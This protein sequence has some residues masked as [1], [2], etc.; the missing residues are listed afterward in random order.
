MKYYTKIA[1]ESPIPVMMYNAP[2]F[3]AGIVFSPDLISALAPHPNIAGMKDTSSENIAIYVNAVPENA[4][5]YVMP[6]TINKMYKGL[7]LGT[8]GG[9]VSMANYLPEQCVKLQELYES[10]QLEEAAKYDVYAR[11]LSSNAA[12]KHG[13]AGVKAAMDLLG[14]VGGNP[15]IP[16]LP[17]SDE[18]KAALKAVFVKEG[19]L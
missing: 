3:A 4:N 16:L 8:I 2:K 9:V 15:R 6:G 17:L 19:L 7:Q 5:F 11:E 1:D 13:V 18:K 12:G 14:Y 10:G